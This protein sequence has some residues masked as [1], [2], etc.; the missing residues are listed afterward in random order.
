[1]TEKSKVDEKKLTWLQMLMSVCSAFIG[2]QSD[3]NLTSD[4]TS[5]RLWP[6]IILGLFV[7]VTFILVLVL[8]VKLILI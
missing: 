1:M 6:F 2:V 7:V 3:K 4:F 5:G 8:I